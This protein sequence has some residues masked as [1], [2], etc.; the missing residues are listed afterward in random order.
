MCWDSA[1]L[2]RG[3]AAGRALKQQLLR[4]TRASFILE[5]AHVVGP[6]NR[7]EVFGCFTGHEAKLAL[8]FRLGSPRFGGDF[9]VSRSSGLQS[10]APICSHGVG[11]PGGT[12][13]GPEFVTCARYYRADTLVTQGHMPQT[14][15]ATSDSKS[16]F[17]L[18]C[19]PNTPQCPRRGGQRYVFSQ[20]FWKDRLWWPLRVIGGWLCGC[21]P[22]TGN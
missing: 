17:A 18:C 7:R 9:C 8:R 14:Q 1:L 21:E 6:K 12:H 5:P 13:D 20:T 4:L 22:Y 15:C 16:G 10:G 19:R 2:A 11:V 3:G